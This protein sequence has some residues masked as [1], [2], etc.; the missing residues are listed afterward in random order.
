[1]KQKVLVGSLFTVTFIAS[2]LLAFLLPHFA[3][4]ALTEPCGLSVPNASGYFFSSYESV[5]YSATGYLQLHFRNQP[6]FSDGRGFQVSWSLVNDECASQNGGSTGMGMPTGVTDW[7]VRFTSMSHFDLWDDT[8]NSVVASINILPA[9]PSYYRVS[10]RGSIDGGASFVNSRT[11]KI[12][13]PGFP[14]EFPDTAE[15]RVE[16]PDITAN[17]YYFDTY[18]HAEYVDGLLRVHVRFKTPFNDGTLSNTRD[19]VVTAGTYSVSEGAVAGWAQTSASC[20]DQSPINAVIVSPGETVTCTFTNTKLS[21][22]VVTELHK[23]DESVVANN[24]SVPLG[25]TMHDKAT[26]SANVGTPTGTVSF[27]FFNNGSCDGTGTAAGTVALVSGV[28]HPATAQGP[29]G[30]GNYSFK[31]HYNGDGNYPASDSACEPF[32]VSKAQLGITTTIHDGSDN[33]IADNTNVPLGTNTHDN[34]TV[35][36]AVSGFPI[37]AISFTLN[38]NAVANTSAEVG[39]SATSVASGALGAGNY[40]YQATVASDANYTGATSAPEPFVVDKASTSVTTEIHKGTDHATDVQGTNI[41]LGSSIHDKA[42]V[43]TQVGSFV[44][45]GTVTYNFYSNDSCTGEPNS[46]ESVAVG[47]ETSAH[48]NLEAG[49]YSFLATYNG[50]SNYAGSVA[51]CEKVHVNKGQLAISTDIHNAA[52]AIITSAGL[53]S[54]VHDTATVTGQVGSIAPTGAVTFTFDKMPSQCGTTAIGTDAGLDSGKARSVDTA[55]LA[56]GSYNFR[57]SIAGDSNYEGATGDCEPLTINKA[58]LGITTTIHDATHGVV[59]NNGHVPL[60]SVMH[61]NATVTGGVNGFPIPAI[62]FTLNAVGVANATTEGG[63]D[64]TSVD[65]A[66]LGAGNY[67]YVATVAGD[68]NYLG[69]TGADEPFVVDKGQLTVTTQVHDALHTDKTNGMVE[70]NSI[71]HDT[72]TV[73]GA[74]LGFTAPTPTFTLTSNYTNSCASGAAVGNNGM[75][76]T[77]YKSADSAAL[78]FGMYAYRAATAA[79]ANYEA[80][81]GDCEPFRV[82]N[83]HTTINIV[84]NVT[85]TQPGENVI[86]TISDTNDGDV[87]LT[88][89][90]VT[91]TYGATVVVLDKDTVGMTGDTG[92]DG[93]MSPG[94]TWTWTVN[95]VINANTTFTVVGDGIDP[96]NNHVSPTTGFPSETKTITVKVI[97][98][99]RTIGFWQTHTDFT[100]YVFNLGTMQ[101]YVGAGLHKGVITNI[102]LPGQSQLFG[103]FYAPIAKKTTGSKRDQIDQARVQMLQQLLAAKLN[104]AAFGCSSTITTLIS[105]ADAAYAAGTNKGLINSL[106]GQLDTFNNSGDSGAIPSG[107]PATGKA[108]PKT[109]QGYANLPFW[110][111][112]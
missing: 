44:I 95:V 69:A 83:P 22:N 32:T 46:N 89:N 43:A 107:L 18:E 58:Q 60:G 29:L 20:S 59:A 105:D 11:F 33:V 91:L 103:G 7:S 102:L 49:D 23:A 110:D 104:C 5:S 35:T 82:I 79:N 76:N 109:S 111:L 50:D 6:R 54:V 63:F 8:N 1:M 108:T 90:T 106:A 112:P 13:Q 45:G 72:A 15:K 56:A 64:A 17:G 30:A 77:A 87:S 25:T 39:F 78:A 65:T 4:A 38:G 37:P 92:A 48:N 41:P 40:T 36:G 93:I 16:C 28:A 61:D 66:A 14:P 42:T 100:S 96:L 99:T 101:K 19:S 84:P 94:E 2:A 88:N 31:A 24:A 81:T 67:V 86:L 52:H 27:T 80:A 55:A 74:V 75:E 57:A 68:D 71:M 70:K 47:S 21:S 98:T 12:Y 51:A 26:V 53:G 34:A 10:F 3:D 97:G 62:S 73:T 9:Y 85:E